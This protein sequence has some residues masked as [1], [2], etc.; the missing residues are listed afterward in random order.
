[1]KTLLLIN[2]HMTFD[3]WRSEL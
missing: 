2:V 3:P 1:M